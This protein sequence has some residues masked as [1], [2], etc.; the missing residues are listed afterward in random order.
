M[1]VAGARRYLSPW[2][3]EPLVRRLDVQL[4]FIYP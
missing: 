4:Q 3:D 2:Q 1:R